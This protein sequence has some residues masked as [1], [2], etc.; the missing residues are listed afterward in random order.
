MPTYTKAD[1]AVCDLVD[2]VCEKFERH[3]PILDA[4]VKI[5]ILMAEPS[6]KQDG[7]PTG[8]AISA[9]GYPALAQ[10]KV[11]PLDERVNGAGD[12][13]MK[14][15][16]DWWLK[17]KPDERDA[18]LDH[19]LTH[20][21]VRTNDKNEIIRD[22]LNRPKLKIRKHDRQF[23]WFDEVALHHPGVAIECQQAMQLASDAGQ[24]YFPGLFAPPADE[25]KVTIKTGDK[26]VTMTG[27][28]FKQACQRI[29]KAAA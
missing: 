14:I 13:L 22:D 10:T 6:V 20:I 2:H 3:H 7:E 8:P 23:G 15:D 26:Q 25:G 24:L 21:E 11:I 4:E 18:L 17:A 5:D 1:Q 28:Q 27:D 19:E 29:A 12:V 9:N 16:A